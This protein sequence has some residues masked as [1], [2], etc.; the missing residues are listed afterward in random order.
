MTFRIP[1]SR[2]PSVSI[3]HISSTLT[4]AV[5]TPSLQSTTESPGCRS[6]T[7]VKE[8]IW[9]QT[10]MARVRRC[11]IGWSLASSGLM[12]PRRTCSAGQEWSWEIRRYLPSRNR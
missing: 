11:F 9:S 1:S 6:I 7:S 4:P 10:P 12:T 5:S 2:L 3:A 8:A